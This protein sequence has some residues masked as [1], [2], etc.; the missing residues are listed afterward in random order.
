VNEGKEAGQSE[1]HLHVH[2]LAGRRM[3]WP[4]G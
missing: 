1:F 4:P 2:V 3:T